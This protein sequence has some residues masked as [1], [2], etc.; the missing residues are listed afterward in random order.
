MSTWQEAIKSSPI[1]QAVRRDV[2]G[3]LIFRFENGYGLKQNK[4]DVCVASSLELMG[5]TDWFPVVQ[6][7]EPDV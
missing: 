5:H 7:G 1:G 4:G 2:R 3:G 6:L